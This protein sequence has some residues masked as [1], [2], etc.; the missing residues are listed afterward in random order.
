MKAGIARSIPHK[1]D[2]KAN[3]FGLEEDYYK[4]IKW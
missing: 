2:F 1:I 3:L 4:W